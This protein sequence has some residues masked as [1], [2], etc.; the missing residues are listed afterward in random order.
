MISPAEE[1]LESLPVREAAVYIQV[2]PDLDSLVTRCNNFHVKPNVIKVR[3]CGEHHNIKQECCGKV[4]ANS[5][6]WFLYT[7]STGFCNFL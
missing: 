3:V 1:T 6:L 5:D 4:A 7:H 2:C